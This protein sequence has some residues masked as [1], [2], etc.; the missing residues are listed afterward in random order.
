MYLKIQQFLPRYLELF[1][2]TIKKFSLELNVVTKKGKNKISN[3]DYYQ[4]FETNYEFLVVDE[5]KQADFIFAFFVL[6]RKEQTFYLNLP[7]FS[8][9]LDK[10]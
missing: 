4:N 10:N 3:F 6:S 8:Q 7:F 2:K 5:H 9:F 1:Q